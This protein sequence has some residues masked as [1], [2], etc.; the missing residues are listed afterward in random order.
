MSTFYKCEHG[1]PCCGI[2]VRG[3]KTENN[4]LEAERD[5]LAKEVQR[6]VNEFANVQRVI[7]WMNDPKRK[8]AMLAFTEGCERQI[9]Y[10]FEAALDPAA[11][12]EGGK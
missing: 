10:T 6:Y 3:A 4:R 9:A 1:E 12:G 5:S 7:A 2:C 8:P 11:D